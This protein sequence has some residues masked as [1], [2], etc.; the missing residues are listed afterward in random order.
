MRTLHVILVCAEAWQLRLAHFTSPARRSPIIFVRATISFAIPVHLYHTTYAH[1]SRV[2]IN[3]PKKCTKVA[4]HLSTRHASKF[5]SLGLRQDFQHHQLP[6]HQ[7]TTRYCWISLLGP[8]P[9]KYLASVVRAS[10][11]SGRQLSRSSCLA[12]LPLLANLIH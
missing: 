10:R 4:L 1:I 3:P 12:P 9:R 2:V 11:A 7:G 6:H 8:F 5:A